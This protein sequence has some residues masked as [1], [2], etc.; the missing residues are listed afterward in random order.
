MRGG[1]QVGCGRD[2][3]DE[4][5]GGRELSVSLCRTVSGLPALGRHVAPETLHTVTDSCVEPACPRQ[6]SLS[7][8]RSRETSK[9]GDPVEFCKSNPNVILTKDRGMEIHHKYIIDEERS[10]PEELSYCRSG[11]GPLRHNPIKNWLFLS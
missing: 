3:L 5:A 6:T 8:P 4:G 11:G 9:G 7:D 1:E 2:A 10:V